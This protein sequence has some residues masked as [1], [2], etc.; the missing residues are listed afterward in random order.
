MKKC[1]V[2]QHVQ[3]DG[4]GAIHTTQGGP[5]RRPGGH[6]H[7]RGPSSN[8]PEVQPNLGAI[9]G[10]PHGQLVWGPVDA[11]VQRARH[12]LGA[13]H[14]LPLAEVLGLGAKGQRE[15]RERGHT[16][17]Q[18]P[19]FNPPKRVLDMAHPEG[20]WQVSQPPRPVAG[21]LVR[22]AGGRLDPAGGG[23]GCLG[24]S[25]GCPVERGLGS[26]RC[27]RP[28]PIDGLDL[29]IGCKG[30][31]HNSTSS[32]HRNSSGR[33]GDRP[34]GHQPEAELGAVAF[35]C[36][37]TNTRIN[38]FMVEDEIQKILS[39]RFHFGVRLHRY[40]AM[41]WFE[42]SLGLNFCKYKL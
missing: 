36:H 23:A 24:G 11:G 37:K 39:D 10:H 41:G 5:T 33:G 21:T 4:L 22:G 12:C 38:A 26:Q 8:R 13:I 29:E 3:Q 18:K 16:H 1:G 32:S 30:G 42:W 20:Q 27:R 31:S 35:E 14:M 28:D 19:H 25:L 17:G 40:V 6:P 9:G 2:C 34:S 7:V 15:G